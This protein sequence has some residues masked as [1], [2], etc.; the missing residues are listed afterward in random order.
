VSDANGSMVDVHDGQEG[1]VCMEEFDSCF[2]DCLG[3]LGG[4]DGVQDVTHMKAIGWIQW[5]S[6]YEG[7][8]W[9][10]VMVGGEL[11]G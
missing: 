8:I 3:L 5:G 11:A 7:V 10:H 9:V 6:T 1:I 4:M 2:S